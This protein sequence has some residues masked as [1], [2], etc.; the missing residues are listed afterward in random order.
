MAS[1]HT[2]AETFAQA[3]QLVDQHGDAGERELLA[4]WQ[5]QCSALPAYHPRQ[6]SLLGKVEALMATLRK[7]SP[8]NQ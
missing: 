8:E 7:R 6:D 4:E 5:R 2:V 3:T 1:S